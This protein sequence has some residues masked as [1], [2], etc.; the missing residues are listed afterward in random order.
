[1][2]F[3]FVSP[4]NN[5]VRSACMLAQSC[6]TLCDPMDCSPSGSSVHG[7]FQAK[8]LEWVATCSSRGSS[9]ARNQIHVSCVSCIGRHILTVEPP[10]KPHSKKNNLLNRLYDLC[11]GGFSLTKS[12]MEV[13]LLLVAGK[14]SSE[15]VDG[16]AMKP[17]VP[18]AEWR[19]QIAATPLT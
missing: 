9:P 3:I 13:N 14:R 17:Q 4:V 2:S 10:G 19:V 8:I 18:E 5:V 15:V 11:R 1:M 6:L 16:V 12:P 7:I